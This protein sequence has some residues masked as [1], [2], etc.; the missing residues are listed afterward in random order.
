MDSVEETIN[1]SVMSKIGI[2]EKNFSGLSNFSMRLD[3][4]NDHIVQIENLTIG[5]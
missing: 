4:L 5:I 2:L 1:S 3:N